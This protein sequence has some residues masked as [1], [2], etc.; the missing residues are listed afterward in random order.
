MNTDFRFALK[1]GAH[2]L[3]D[4]VDA[5]FSRLNLQQ[6]DD[7][8]R[9]LSLHAQCFAVIR[10]QADAQCRTLDLQDRMVAALSADLRMLGRA[11]SN[12]AHSDLEAPHRPDPLAI[13]YVVAGS[14]LGSRLLASR[15]EE[16]EDASVLSA[17]AYLGLSH[18]PEL[19][20]SVCAA[21]SAL[22]P[23]SARAETIQAD[24]N[25]LFEL[26]IASWRASVALPIAEGFA[27]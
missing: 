18:D 15:W 22:E 16:S 11:A 5:L 1:A 23:A 19:W 2:E 27:Q 25:A 14:R 7:Y 26:F 13:D 8:V 12:G 24:V 3:H 4:S 6:Y 21:L 17:G 10:A 9:F 20:R